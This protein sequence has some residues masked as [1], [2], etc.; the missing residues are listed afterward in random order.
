M[1]FLKYNPANKG[2]M[3]KPASNK[4]K[5][6]KPDDKKD[7]SKD[8][9]KDEPKKD[10]KI[11]VEPIMPDSKIPDAIVNNMLNSPT[12]NDKTINQID[13]ELIRGEVY[14]HKKPKM[15]TKKHRVKKTNTKKKWIN[16][17]VKPWVNPWD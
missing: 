16:R 15:F 10:E 12:N 14:E 5:D 4:Q 9:K 11:Y 13:R 2:K 8:D 1:W 7:E 6:D 17:L 3:V